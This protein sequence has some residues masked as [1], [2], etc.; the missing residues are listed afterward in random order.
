MDYVLCITSTISEPNLHNDLSIVRLDQCKSATNYFSYVHDTWPPL[1]A[2]LPRHTHKSTLDTIWTYEAP[3]F[4]YDYCFSLCEHCFAHYA[5][6]CRRRW[7][8]FEIARHPTRRTTCS[9]VLHTFTCIS[10]ALDPPIGDPHR[11]SSEFTANTNT[12]RH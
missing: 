1:K 8:P 7:L 3:R 12:S 10:S 5:S 2:P 9:I 11:R 4:L 6:L